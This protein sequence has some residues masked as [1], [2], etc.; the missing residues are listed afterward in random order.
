MTE[1]EKQ[2]ALRIK[3]RALM[4]ELDKFADELTDESN[5]HRVFLAWQRIRAI[6]IN[7]EAK[8]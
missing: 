1:I 7:N 5:K 8:K 2:N 6:K 4:D 3:Q